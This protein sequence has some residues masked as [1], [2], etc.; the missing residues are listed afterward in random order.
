MGYALPGSCGVATFSDGPVVSYNGDGSVMMNLQELQTVVRNHFNIKIV[1]INNDGY[2]G[3]RHGQKAHF[4]GKSIGTDESN[5]L[6][7][8]S[9][10]KLA[11]A[12]GIKYLKISTYSEIKDKVSE[13]FS[14]N[15]PCILE[16]ICDPKQF[17]LHNGLVM[18]G[19]RKFGFR[20]IEDQSP[21]LDRDLFFKEMIVKPM[22]TSYGKPV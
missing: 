17:D 19:K 6:T 1:I 22:D 3:V 20:P 12:F 13:M 5:G 4:R 2:S 21:Y 11:V 14:N 7:L 18:Y 10:E 15:E 8:P 16:V 9:F